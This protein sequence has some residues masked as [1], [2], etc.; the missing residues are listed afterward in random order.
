MSLIKAN[1]VQVG[2]SPTATQNFTLAVPSSPDG[3]IKLARGNA[4][5]TT[6]DVLSV[7]ASGNINGLVK[8]TGS[9]TARSLANRFADV[10]NVKDFGAVGDGVTDDTTAIQAALNS[11]SKNQTVIISGR[12]R[13]SNI[14]IPKF[15]SLVGMGSNI[16]ATDTYDS[17]FFTGTNSTLLLNSGSTISMQNGACLENAYIFPYGMTFPQISSSGW[18]GTAITIKA[19]VGI[20]TVDV[21]LKNL[22]I[23]GFNLAVDSA[24]VPRLICDNVNFD[25]QSGIKVDTAGDPIKFFNCHGWPFA[26][27]AATNPSGAGA[28]DRRT[29][30]AFQ[31]LNNADA[32]KITNCF[33]FGY[34]IGF[35][36]DSATGITFVNCGADDYNLILPITSYGWII[37]GNSAFTNLTSCQSVAHIY[38]VDVNL[39][40]EDH[41]VQIIGG[42]Y[43]ANTQD[44][45]H[46]QIGKVNISGSQFWSSQRCV[47]LY[48][49]ANRLSFD[50]CTIEN[51]TNEVILNNAGTPFVYIGSN[52]ITNGV[53]CPMHFSVAPVEVSVPSATT[54]AL[55]ISGNAFL[56]TGTTDIFYMTGGW[57]GRIVVLK[58]NGVLTVSDATTSFQLAGNFT[59]SADDTLTLVAISNTQWVEVTRS[60]N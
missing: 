44:S 15:V 47:G 42:L 36:I 38:G 48:S 17:N 39:S 14:T 40:S 53:T 28:R 56:I 7:D 23:C 51:Q 6:Q 5:A 41:V 52:N 20:N 1:A 19:G 4:G 35:Q 34:Y 26:T 8:T 54:V 9:T 43:G 33:S 60:I 55:P 59:T 3:T 30:R 22:L 37:N 29:G 21:T 18:S 2:Q 46:I 32:G 27:I 58:F 12:Y 24:Y 16:G 31:F 10:I 25:C 11:A 49:A 45:I 50:N 57:P 13:V